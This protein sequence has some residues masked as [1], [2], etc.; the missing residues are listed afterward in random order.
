ML[1]RH[2]SPNYYKQLRPTS[3]DTIEKNRDSE[4]YLQ[5]RIETEKQYHQLLN[6]PADNSFIYATIVGF[7]K[8]EKA[9]T[10]PG[11]TYYFKL[12]PEQIKNTIFQV[13]GQ[14]KHTTEPMRGRKGLLTAI[15][16]WIDNKGQL[17]P[18]YDSVVGGNIDPRIEVIIGYPVKYTIYIPQ[19]E[20]R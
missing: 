1:F 5:D 6:Q 15:K 11:Y 20:D 16:Y 3:Y 12:S 14:G 4:Q 17:K 8:M 9:N 19:E 10:Y 2:Q 18:Y 13:V 7:H